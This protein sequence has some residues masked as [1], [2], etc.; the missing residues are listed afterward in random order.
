MSALSRSHSDAAAV[1]YAAHQ[2]RKGTINS[3][4]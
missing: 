1:P 2:M 3:C 4:A